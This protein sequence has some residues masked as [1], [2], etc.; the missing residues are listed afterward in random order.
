MLTVEATTEYILSRKHID[1]ILI[2]GRQMTFDIG[3]EKR[4]LGVDDGKSFYVSDTNDLSTYS[5]FRYR[6]AQFIDDLNIEQQDLLELLSPEE[7]AE[8]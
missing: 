8:S 6:L 4:V 3:D 2:L 5:L 7:Q 1:E